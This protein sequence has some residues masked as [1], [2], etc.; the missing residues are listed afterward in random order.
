MNRI[1][2]VSKSGR[3]GADGSPSD[4]LG[5]IQEAACQARSGDEIVVHAGIYRERIDPPQGGTADDQRIT[6]RAADGE[7][8]EIRGSEVLKGWERVEGPVWKANVPDAVFGDFNPF[9]D[10]VAGDWFTSKGR[11]HHTGAVYLNGLWFSEAASLEEVLHSAEPVPLWFARVEADVT[12]VWARFGNANPNEEEVE[13]NVRQSVFYPATTGINFLTVRGFT[14]RHAATP[15]APP[16]AEQIGVIGT[17]WSKGWIIEQNVISDS[18]CCGIALGKNGDEWDNQSANKAEGYNETIARALLANWRRG[19]IGHHIV[20]NNTVSRCEQA[21]IVGS[22]GAAFSVI[23]GNHVHGIWS[24]RLF[25][26]EEMA[27]IKLHGAIDT[28]IKGN[29][30]HHAGRGLWLDWMSQGTRVSG[31]LFYSN[32]VDDLFMEVNHGPHL[33]DNNFFLSKVSLRDWSEGGAYAHNLFAGK[34]SVLPQS[35]RTP[36][37]LPH[38]TSL[39]GIVDFH[40]LDNRFF[41]N[42]FIGEWPSAQ[43]WTHF[44]YGRSGY[45]LWPYGDYKATLTTGGNLYYCGARP[46]PAETGFTEMLGIDP[47]IRLTEDADRVELSFRLGPIR[48]FGPASA[49]T[50]ASLVMASTPHAPFVN[51]D[52]SPLAVDI[53]YRGRRRDPDHPTPGPLEATEDA[54]FSVQI[55]AAASGGILVNPRND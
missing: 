4:P 54:L 34:I 41:N 10:L 3:C 43:E 11:P 25:E 30:I 16:T 9:A 37:H 39:L 12:T 52:D 38:S 46:W 42:L 23:S 21:G 50:T 48:T 45:G 32:T 2:H 5:T 29:A 24:K 22:L 49:V 17:N 36:F 15:W 27:G 40:R 51:P 53:D 14:M 31:N 8:V 55:Q 47:N 33:V 44:E 28:A 20:R 6:F 35:R 7:R 19:E 18:I 1:F 13:I 26:G